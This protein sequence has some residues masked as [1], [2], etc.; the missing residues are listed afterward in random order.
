MHTRSEQIHA[1]SVALVHA[2]SVALVVALFAAALSIMTGCS[3]IDITNPGF[4]AAISASSN[5]IRVNEQIQLKTNI[6]ATGSSWPF[7]VRGESGNAT[8]GVTASGAG[9][10]Q[11]EPSVRFPTTKPAR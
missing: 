8:Y 10:R 3:A 6:N 7:P 11:A 9:R 5:T 2:L 1:L 4:F